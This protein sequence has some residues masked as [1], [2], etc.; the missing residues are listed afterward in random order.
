MTHLLITATFEVAIDEAVPTTQVLHELKRKLCLCG[1]R[2]VYS[3][4]TWIRDMYPHL[5]SHAKPAVEEKVCRYDTVP[6]MC[7]KYKITLKKTKWRWQVLDPQPTGEV[8]GIPDLRG[9]L[10]LSNGILAILVQGKKWMEVHLEN[11]I[12]D[13]E[14]QVAEHRRKPFKSAQPK[15]TRFQKALAEY[16]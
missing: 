3:N 1:Q 9:R 14:E 8:S 13:E 5:K 10:I 4:I 16:D 7:E 15:L 11:F 12:A 6:L 2:P